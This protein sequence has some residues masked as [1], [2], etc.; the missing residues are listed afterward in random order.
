VEVVNTEEKDFNVIWIT[1]DLER[2]T[3]LIQCDVSGAITDNMTAKKVHGQSSRRSA[4][5]NF[6]IDV[7]PVGTIYW[8]KIYSQQPRL[9]V[10]DD[11]TIQH[12]I[13]MIIL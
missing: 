5:A 11:L 1:E 4:S 7:S 3:K 8:S 9:R 12:H 13:L 10:P 6:S 2:V